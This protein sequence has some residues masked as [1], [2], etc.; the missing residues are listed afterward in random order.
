MES[1]GKQVEAYRI[2]QQSCEAEHKPRPKNAGVLIFDE[3]K[4]VPSLTEYRIIGLAMTVEAQASLHDVQCI[5][6]V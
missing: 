5:P 6:A 2:F 3:V 1:I 4:V